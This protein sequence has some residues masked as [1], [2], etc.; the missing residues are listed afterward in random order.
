MVGTWYYVVGATSDTFQVAATDGGA[1]IVLT[2]VGTGSNEA[3][4][5]APVA[6]VWVYEMLTSGVTAPE[7]MPDITEVNS[8]AQRGWELMFMGQGTSRVAVDFWYLMRKQEPA[9]GMTAGQVNFFLDAV[10]DPL[11]PDS[12]P[13]FDGGQFSNLRANLLQPNQSKILCELRRGQTGEGADTAGDN[14][15][16]GTGPPSGVADTIIQGLTSYQTPDSNY[17]VAANN[18]KIWKLG[19]G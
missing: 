18:A 16:L 12:V 13:T 17:V 5:P 10:D 7:Y 9:S 2:T 1:A 8:Y 6:N 4:S 14:R 19:R 11:L 15:L 3:W